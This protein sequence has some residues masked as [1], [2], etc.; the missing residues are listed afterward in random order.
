MEMHVEEP[1]GDITRVRLVGRM[2]YAGATEIDARFMELA[3]REKFLLVDLSQVNFLA[4]MGIRTLI[5]A[6]KA[7]K[8]RG[9][10]MILF[11]PE[12]M[13]AKVLKTSGTDTLIPVYYDLLLARMALQPRVPKS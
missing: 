12:M 6:A 2:D 8:E 4:S 9:G 7:L 1:D 11:S 5:M 10:K 13:V 3:G